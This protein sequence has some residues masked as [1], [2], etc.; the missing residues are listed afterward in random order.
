MERKVIGQASFTYNESK[1][2]IFVEPGQTGSLTEVAEDAAPRIIDTTVTWKIQEIRAFV[3][4]DPVRWRMA[5]NLQ[6]HCSLQE[7]FQ[8]TH[9]IPPDDTRPF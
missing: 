6:Q 1:F 7:K 8:F 5:C 3:G 2:M 4:P 9:F